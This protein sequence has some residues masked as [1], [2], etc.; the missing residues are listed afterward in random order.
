MAAARPEPEHWTEEARAAIAGYEKEF[1]QGRYL[2]NMRLSSALAIDRKDWP[3]AFRDLTA[4]LD[5]AGQA[6][7]HLDAAL[8]LGYA[9]MQ[10]IDQPN[11]RGAMV[12]ALQAQ[13]AAQLRLWQFMR[14]PTPGARLRVLE[15]F[16][17]EQL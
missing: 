14:S 2:A 1:P 10:L 3:S 8:N 11:Q 17:R 5:D 12:P 7:L 13:P 4:T 15:G 16:L 6:D 9:Y